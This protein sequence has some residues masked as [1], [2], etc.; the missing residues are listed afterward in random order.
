MSTQLSLFKHLVLELLASRQDARVP[1]PELIM[2]DTDQAEA[3]MLAGREDGVIA[4]TYLFHTLQLSQLIKPGDDV[5]DLACGPANQLAQVARVHPDANF[6]GVD[7][8]PEMLELAGE[9]VQRFGLENVRFETRYIQNLEGMTD[10]SMDVVMS[11]M[12]LH[13]L[14]DVSVLQ[15]TFREAAR[16]LKPDGAVYLAD[17]SR[18]KREQT[19]RFFAE[20]HK[21]QQSEIFT[22]D[23]LNSLRAAFTSQEFKQAMGIFGPSTRFNSTALVPF[24]VVVHR[25]ERHTVTNKALE[26]CQAIFQGLHPAQQQDFSDLKHF[27]SLGGLPTPQFL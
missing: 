8:S 14:P 12:S 4:P 1:E 6:V 21:E 25:G 20:Q 9:T 15:A 24:M 10:N 22:A 23:Y 18:L 2:D 26:E 7:A 16:V 19:R 3:F 13:H 27:F 17:F 5:L 11:T